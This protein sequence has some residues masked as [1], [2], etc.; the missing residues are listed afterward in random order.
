MKSNVSRLAALVVMVL[1]V[2]RAAAAAPADPPRL[3]AAADALS[4]I[5]GVEMFDCDPARRPGRPR[6]RLVPSRPRAATTGN[7]WP[8]AW[9]PT[10]T[11][12]SPPTSSPG[13]GNCSTASTATTTA[14]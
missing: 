5:E 7:G 1:A 14:G 3:S 8:A 11:A 12:P 6:R 13:R 9:T 10:T 2:G 4:R